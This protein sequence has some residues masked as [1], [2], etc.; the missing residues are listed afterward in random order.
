M[1]KLAYILTISL[2]LGSC[3]SLVE[4]EVF[5][6]ITPSNF[7]QNERDVATAVNGVYDGIQDH[8]LWWRQF[9]TTELTG[10]L[11]RHNWAPW[12]E[13]MVYENDQGDIWNLW[14][15]N[16]SVI[17]RA[18]TVLDVMED[19][20][21]DESLKNRY[22]AE[23]RFL[24]AYVYFNLVRLFGQ[25]PLVTSP[26][27]SL[28]EVVVPDST[29][30]EAFESE[31]TKQLDRDAIYDFIIEDLTFAE[32]NLPDS[33]NDNEA[34]RATSGAASGMLARVYL[35][36]AGRQYDYNTGE[37]VQ[38]DPSVYANVVEQTDKLM[39]G[40]YALMDNYSDIYEI[41]INPEIVFSIQYLESAVAGVTGEGNQIQPRTGIRGAT[42][43]TPY[44]WLQCSVN[45][46]FWQDF[47]EHNSK[48]DERYWRTFLEYYVK[49]NGDTV[50]HGSSSTFRRP[51]V[52]KFLTDL[53]PDT[54][55]QGATD[56]GADWIVMRYADVLL[57]N[58]EALNEMSATPD[59]TTIEGINQV[60]T[61]A[62]KPLITL[63]ISQADLREAIWE[64]RRW[65]L[66]FEGLHYFDCQ[67][68]G[69]LL[70]EFAKYPNEARQAQA[71][72]RHYIYPIPFDAM[73]ANPSLEQNAGW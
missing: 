36:I 59:A 7:F 4:E 13:T 19:S 33:Y 48:Q 34:G 3:E 5:S 50:W 32:A 12:A 49:T 72:M 8:N 22:A 57:M 66:C 45:E 67:R 69:R 73:Q 17:G 2:A 40:S 1:K 14:W 58:S 16:Y 10:G 63:P 65:E 11:M 56:Y 6:A 43:F 15:R 39:G 60:R 28:G 46:P 18:N 51:H 9:Y 54:K 27:S 21:L 42:D 25:I 71:T 52:R 68:T 20:E 62:E 41:A 29:A 35:A 30:T 24:R 37:L 38:G 23:V 44:A 26:P 31:Y 55:A 61:R 70:K 53:G 64:E 47:I